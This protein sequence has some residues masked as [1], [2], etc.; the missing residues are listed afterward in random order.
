LQLEEQPSPLIVL[1]S[2]QS[3]P[4]ITGPSGWAGMTMPS[5]HL[6]V[7]MPVAALQLGS[8][9]QVAEQPSPGV[10]L[11]SSQLSLPS[12]T[13]SPHFVAWQLVVL[14]AQPEFHLQVLA[15]A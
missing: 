2:S 7:Q 11:P 10:V 12:G 3:P 14:Q 4:G 15:H 8:T 1:P 6:E 13:P 9:R 5:P